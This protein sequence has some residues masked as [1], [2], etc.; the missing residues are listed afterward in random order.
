M[1][2]FAAANAS[3]TNLSPTYDAAFLSI[4]E[5]GSAQQFVGGSVSLKTMPKD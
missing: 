2:A 1:A 5:H 3:T 4:A